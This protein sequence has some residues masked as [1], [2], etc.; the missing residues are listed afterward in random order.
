M[1]FDYLAENRR[2]AE[3]NEQR[4]ARTRLE[5]IERERLDLEKQRLWA[6]EREQP[7]GNGILGLALV[8]L[9]A[10]GIVWGIVWLSRVL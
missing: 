8:V 5:M 3:Q 6:I 7:H 9:V 10:G 2:L 1:P 4:Q